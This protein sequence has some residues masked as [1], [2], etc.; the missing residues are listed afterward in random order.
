MQRKLK[1][2][3]ADKEALLLVKEKL[4]T[5]YSCRPTI[6]VLCKF[7]GLNSN[8]LKKG[9]KIIY[10]MAPY[11]FYLS[12]KMKE[13]QRLLRETEQTVSEI[14][15]GIGYETPNSFCKAF[16]KHTGATPLEWRNNNL[17]V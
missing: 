10:G 4:E 8:K 12:L 2:S 14:G 6:K 7:S 5:D 15:W 11:A 16:R 1:I 13:A 17:C 3:E 9:F